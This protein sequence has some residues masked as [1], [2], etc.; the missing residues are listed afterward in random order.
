VGIVFKKIL[1]L[2]AVAVL[3]DTIDSDNKTT[4]IFFEL[5]ST[6]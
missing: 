1:P 2:I 3:P 5:I 6:E 4:A